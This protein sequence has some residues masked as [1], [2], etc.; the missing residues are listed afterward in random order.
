[1]EQWSFGMRLDSWPGR[2]DTE[3]KK[4]PFMLIIGDNEKEANNVSVRKQGEGDLGS[5]TIEEFANYFNG[6]L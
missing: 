2:S 6:L 5:M 3:L 4:I 1:M